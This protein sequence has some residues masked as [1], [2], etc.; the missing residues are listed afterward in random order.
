MELFTKCNRCSALMQARCVDNGFARK[1]HLVPCVMTGEMSSD[2]VTAGDEIAHTVLC[3]DCT[4][5]L[6]A[7]LAG[8]PEEPQE[9][10]GSAGDDDVKALAR[11]MAR[12]LVSAAKENGGDQAVACGYFGYW[13]VPCIGCGTATCPA[14]ARSREGCFNVMSDDVGKRCKALGIDLDGD[15]DAGR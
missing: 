10:A 11:D 12:G 1:T 2:D 4:A 7:W 8:E 14:F 5:K 9:A 6:K 13:G 15:E 3:P